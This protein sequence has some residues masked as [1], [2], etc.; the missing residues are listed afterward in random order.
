[1]DG[2]EGEERR[3]YVIDAEGGR[4]PM[5]RVKGEEMKCWQSVV[6]QKMSAC[7]LNT[8]AAILSETYRA[9]HD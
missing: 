4:S 6:V 3:G 1:L 9:F 7:E 5:M 2:L 8:E